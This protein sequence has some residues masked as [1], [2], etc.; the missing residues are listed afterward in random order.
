MADLLLGVRA[1]V[2]S[3]ERERRDRALLDIQFVKLAGIVLRVSFIHGPKKIT[4]RRGARVAGIMREWGLVLLF[5]AT[6]RSTTGFMDLPGQ[7][8]TL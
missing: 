5:L 7:V 4:S 8:M 6:Q 3:A 1:G 2:V